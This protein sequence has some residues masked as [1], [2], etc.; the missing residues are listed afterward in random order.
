MMKLLSKINKKTNV[1]T[2]IYYPILEFQE[3]IKRRGGVILDKHDVYKVLTNSQFNSNEVKIKL[4]NLVSNN[5]SDQIKEDLYLLK[6]AYY[7]KI[8]TIQPKGYF[9]EMTLVRP[10]ESFFENGNAK[11]KISLK[12]DQLVTLLNPANSVLI[13][14]QNGDLIVIF[15]SNYSNIARLI[16]NFN[17]SKLKNMNKFNMKKPTSSF[18][19]CLSILIVGLLFCTTYY[20]VNKDNGRYEYKSGLVIDKQT[21]EAKQI[22]IK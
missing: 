4:C 10:N 7:I 3:E 15:N 9:W 6:K 1:S 2:D 18:W 5:Y 20:F 19:I 13:E 14:Y 17:Q 8:N 12:D 11:Y 21:G 22:K 16:N